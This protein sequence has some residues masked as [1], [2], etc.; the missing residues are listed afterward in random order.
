MDLDPKDLWAIMRFVDRSVLGDS[1]KT[2]QSHFLVEPTIDLSK[3][4]GMVQRKKMMLAYQIAKRKAPMRED[5]LDEYADLISPHVMR[6]S[7]EEAGI[8]A[9]RIHLIEFDLDPEERKKYETLERTMV[10]KHRG[11]K[12]KTPLKITQIGKL[13]QMTGGHIKD[14]EGEVHRIGTSKRRWLRRLIREHVKPGKPFVVFCK[15][16]WEV[17][18]IARLLERM[19][20]GKGASLWGKVKDLKR[21]K[22]RTNMLLAFQRGEYDWMVC[23][24]RTGGVGVDLYRARKFFVYSM[25]H[26]FIDFDQMLSR[27][28]FLEQTQRSDF[29]LL[30]ARRSIDIDVFTSVSKKKS[31]TE[32]FYGRLQH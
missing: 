20:L 7:K 24:Q 30:A 12:I 9:A 25:G 8:E 21:D 27:G 28:D 2:F 22:R 4:M 11:K 6:I 13:Q 16:V 19:D 26:S 32:A 3:R 10:V 1:W 14:E 15:Y 18:M 29:F 17:H 31:I 23:Q 5:R